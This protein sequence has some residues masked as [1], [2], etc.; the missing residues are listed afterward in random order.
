M[1]VCK[2]EAWGIDCL[3]AKNLLHLPVDKDE[4][5]ITSSVPTWIH[6]YVQFWRHLDQDAS[7]L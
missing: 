4:K 2:M 7:V 3:A 5:S 6:D 1:W